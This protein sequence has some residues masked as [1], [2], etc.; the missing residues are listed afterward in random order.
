MLNIPR[1]EKFRAPSGQILDYYDLFLIQEMEANRTIE[2]SDKEVTFNS[3][4]QCNVYLRMRSDL[5]HNVPLLLR[6]G[7]QIKKT[8]L[9]LRPTHGPKFCLIGI[10][11]AGTPLAQ[12]AAMASFD[13]QRQLTSTICFRQLRSELKKGHG[14]TADTMWAGPPELEHYSPATVE[15][16]VST[17]KAYF[18]HLKHLEEDGYPTKEMWH[19]AFAD[20]ELGG[21]EALSDA[22]YTNGLVLYRMRDMIAAL[23]HLGVWPAEY[24]QETNRRVNAWRVAKGLNTR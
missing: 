7:H 1:H 10:P 4:F 11:T 5:T 6:A 17:A 3:G 23:V 2:W 14:K 20:W 15:N 16:V 22:G 12:A 13:P 21:T 8:I 24:Y 18:D 9:G 19:I